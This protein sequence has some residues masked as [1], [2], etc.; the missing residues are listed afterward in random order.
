[1][2][3]TAVIF[4]AGVVLVLFGLFRS[5]FCSKF[6]KGI[7]FTGAGT[8]MAV[9]A[10]FLIAGWNGTAY[11]PSTADIQSSLTISNSCSSFFTLKTMTY[12]SFLIPFVIAYIAYAWKQ[13]DKKPITEDEIEH[14]DLKY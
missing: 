14:T 11:Y 3:V 4:V 8:V 2:P 9:T 7:W 5:I 12:V 6:K 1:M 10:L 13:M